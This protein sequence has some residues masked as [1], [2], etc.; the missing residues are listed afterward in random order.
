MEV[1]CAPI[2]DDIPVSV[3]ALTLSLTVLTVAITV[4]QNYKLAKTKSSAGLSVRPSSQ[5]KEE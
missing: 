4:P 5:P 2:V 3:Q 1:S